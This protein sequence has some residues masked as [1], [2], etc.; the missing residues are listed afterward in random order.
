MNQPGFPSGLVKQS[1]Y[2]QGIVIRGGK[3]ADG[4]G[5][6]ARNDLI[7]NGLFIVG[8][9]MTDQTDIPWINSL[10][11]DRIGLQTSGYSFNVG[12][13]QRDDRLGASEILQHIIDR[14]SIFSDQGFHIPGVRATE[15]VDVL[16]I[17]TDRYDPHILIATDKFL[18]QSEFLLTKV[19]C[20]VD[21]KD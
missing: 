13:R 20:L 5:I 19:L 9:G 1:R 8:S 7:D 15:F 6:I 3:N 4:T 11:Y 10:T 21:D 18:D 16:V 14:R 2:H 12:V 17:V